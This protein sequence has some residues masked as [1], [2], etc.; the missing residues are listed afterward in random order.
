MASQGPNIAGAAFDGSDAS[1]PWQNPGNATLDD[2]SYATVDVLDKDVA[3]NSLLAHQFNFSIPS[4]STINGIE[5]T[6]DRGVFSGSNRVLDATVQL[7]LDGY[8]LSDNRADTVTEW[9]TGTKT[10]GGSSDL[11]GLTPTVGLINDTDGFGFLINVEGTTNGETV[12]VGI[13]AIWITVYYTPPGITFDAASN[14]GYQA[15][16]SNYTFNRTVGAGD[17][18][19]LRV[20]VAILG[21]PGA[22]VTSITDDDGG[23]NVALTRIGV[24]SSMTSAGIAEFWGLAAP[25]SGTKSIRVQLSGSVVSAAIAASYAGVNQIV[26]YA[27]FNYA[28]ATNVG[29]AD[30]SVN[31]TTVV[32]DSWAVAALATDDANV[33]AGQTG[34]NEVNGVGG[35]GANEDTNGT[36]S[37]GTTAMSY[38]D[39]GA[40]ATWVIGGY[41][42]RSLNAPSGDDNTFV[43]SM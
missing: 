4:G 12:N 27:N 35:S 8:I 42:L 37:P 24:G 39:V 41:E 15:A 32:S 43:C 10:Y 30:A 1:A 33:T 28:Q 38:T 16:S 40:L 6:V 22:S 25:V 36:V 26:P 17:N 23:G 9:T 21:A 31:I 34:R 19:F 29:A 20:E 7:I 5:V 3:T 13:D 14:S 11:W 18:R 2:G